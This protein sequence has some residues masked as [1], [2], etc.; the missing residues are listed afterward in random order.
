MRGKGLDSIEQAARRLAVSKDTLKSI[1]S[2]KGKPKYG[3][4][5]LKR[6]IEEITPPKPE[7]E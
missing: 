7:G 4:E 1:M 5:T 6:V 2:S 3:P